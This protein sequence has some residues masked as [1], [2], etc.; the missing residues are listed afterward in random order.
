MAPYVDPH[1]R[2][3]GEVVR[4]YKRVLVPEVNL[5]QL[6]KLVRSEFLVDAQGLNKVGGLPLRRTDVELAIASQLEMLRTE[7]R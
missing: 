6:R 1:P 4:S 7:G 2:N 5:G 3:L